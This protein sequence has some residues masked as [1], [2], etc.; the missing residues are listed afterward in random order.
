MTNIFYIIIAGIIVA[1]ILAFWQFFLF[2]IGVLF[3]AGILRS[4]FTPMAPYNR[5]P[6]FD[7]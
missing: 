7:R 2:V 4:V 3:V 6:L 1:I 5:K